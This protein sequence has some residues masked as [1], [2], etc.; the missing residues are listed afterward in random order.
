M[1]NEY[2][3]ILVLSSNFLILIGRYASL[4]KAEGPK[5]YETL[6]LCALFLQLSQNKRKQN[7]LAYNAACSDRDVDVIK[8]RTFL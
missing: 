4:R 6:I 5:N 1:C 7:V 3:R 2:Y 8:Y